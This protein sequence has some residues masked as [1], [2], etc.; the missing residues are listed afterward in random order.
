MENIPFVQ[1]P[2]L[3]DPEKMRADLAAVQPE[4]WIKH[5]RGEHYEGAWSVAPLRSVAGHPAIIHAVPGGSDPDFYRSTP[6]LDRCPYFREVISRFQCRVNA[7]RLM[8]LGPG[9]RILEHSDDMGEG[10]AQ[11][12]RLHIAI[13]TNPGVEFR[14]GGQIVPMQ[15]GELWYADFNLPH[16]VQNKGDTDRVHFVLD[17]EYNPWLFQQIE[18]AGLIDRMRRF[19]H[20]IGIETC[21]DS[22]D[23]PTFLPGIRIENGTLRIDPEKLLHPGDIL[24]EAGH[25]AVTPETERAKLNGNIGEG[26]TNALGNE[27]AAILWSFAALKA[28][29]VPEDVVFHPNGYKGQSDWFIEQFR[30]RGSYI[31]LPLL[32]WMGF[33]LGPEQ[34]RAKGAEPFPAMLR[35]LR[36]ASTGAAAP[37]EG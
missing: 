10:D 23:E 2:L 13:Q 34:A 26:E 15:S 1:L 6:L 11:E 3:F 33:T 19:L 32:E 28:A 35:W 18:K 27:I 16:S 9:A 5:Y 14:L 22:I 7:V 25:I 21:F 20:R 29:G 4:E 8:S 12:L 36:G 31:G 30:D 37:I 17:C 24:H